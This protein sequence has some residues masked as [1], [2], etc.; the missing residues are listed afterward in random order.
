[1]ADWHLLFPTKY[2]SPADFGG[3]QAD[4]KIAKIWLGNL[5]GTEEKNGETVSVQKRAG[6]MLFEGIEKE[7]VVKL[8]VG[9]ALAMMWGEDASKWN[10]HV[11]TFYYPVEKWFAE[12]KP[13]LRCRGAPDLKT[14]ISK[15]VLIGRRKYKIDL[16]NTGAKRVAEPVADSISL[17]DLTGEDHDATNS[18]IDSQKMRDAEVFS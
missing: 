7:Y 6:F 3:K 12:T 9:H 2:L 17:A 14:P 18:A 5:D 1:M 10:G 16:I 8:A 13:R 4:V 15:T 11:F